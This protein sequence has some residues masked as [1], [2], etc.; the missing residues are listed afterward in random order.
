[1]KVN[2]KAQKLSFLCIF[3]SVYCPGNEVAY[4]DGKYFD[5][6]SLTNLYNSKH[7][8]GIYVNPVTNIYTC[9]LNI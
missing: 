6:S 1:M 7:I 2:Q 4:T 3:F 8:H 9:N 5:V